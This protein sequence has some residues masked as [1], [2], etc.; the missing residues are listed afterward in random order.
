MIRYHA[1]PKEVPGKSDGERLK[2]AAHGGLGLIIHG[3]RIACSKE[4][5]MD[6]AVALNQGRPSEGPRSLWESVYGQTKQM[7]VRWAS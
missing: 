3:R 7:G 5:G 2:P 6:L 1:H 4:C